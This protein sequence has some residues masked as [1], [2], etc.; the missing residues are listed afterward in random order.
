[1]KHSG[2]SGTLLALALAGCSAAEAPVAPPPGPPAPVVLSFPAEAGAGA[3]ADIVADAVELEAE[4]RAL[5]APFAAQMLD[6]VQQAMAAGGPVAA[7]GACQLLAPGIAS[8][9]SRAPW[10]VGRTALRVRNPANAP[11]AWERAVL[12]RFVVAAAEGRPLSELRH[13]EVVGGEYRYLQAIATGAPCLACH[14]SN[15][16]K[17]VQAILR[18]KYPQDAA[19]G[20]AAGDLRGA[21]TLRRMLD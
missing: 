4:A 7:I 13:G 2:I 21:F 8:E 17:P 5:V 18:E 6:T 20:F 11:D 9:H 15:L 14:G 10:T 16:P 1:M 12:E 19:T 3:G